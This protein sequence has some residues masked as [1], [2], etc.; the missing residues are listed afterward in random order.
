MQPEPPTRGAGPLSGHAPRLDTLELDTGQHNLG[1]P[2]STLELAPV[3]YACADPDTRG[4]GMVASE[5]TMRVL[6]AGLALPLESLEP[7]DRRVAATIVATCAREHRV[8]PEAV[9][10]EVFTVAAQPNQ[11]G[12]RWWGALCYRQ[13]DG[14]TWGATYGADD[15]AASCYCD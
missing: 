5:H 9:R 4:L 11:Y 1:A 15:T 12:H 6:E 14:H 8:G 13:P 3:V 7:A 10:L 2:W